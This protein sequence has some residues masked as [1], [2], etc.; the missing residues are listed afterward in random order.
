[1]NNERTYVSYLK[2]YFE[3]AKKHL[4]PYKYINIALGHC[5]PLVVKPTGSDNKL[6][7]RSNISYAIVQ[8]LN[9]F[10]NGGW[11]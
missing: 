4:E 3:I 5:S 2:C 11:L 6:Y 9:Y 10:A 8:P 1:M 7:I